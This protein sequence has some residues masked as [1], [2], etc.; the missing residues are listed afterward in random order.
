MLRGRGNCLA[1]CRLLARILPIGS[2]IIHILV[3]G[4]AFVA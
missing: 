1:L 4:T 2:K 3:S